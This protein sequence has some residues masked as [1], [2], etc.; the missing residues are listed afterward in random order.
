MSRRLIVIG[1]VVVVAVVTGLIVWLA[2]GRRPAGPDFREKK[3]EE[4]REYL[5]SEAFRNMDRE[6]RRGIARRAME[7]MMTGRARAYF[8]LPVEERV[9]YLD[10]IIDEMESRRREFR[11][12]RGEFRRG[13]RG[14]EER[15]E[16]RGG[17]GERVRFRSA[18]PDGRGGR[19]GQGRPRWGR[20]RRG[21]WRSPERRRRRSEFVDAETRAIRAKFREALR[22]RMRERGMDFGRR[23]G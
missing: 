10:K 21:R 14:S 7:Q 2:V 11:S 13:R 1:S 3:P 8:E 18:G 22:Q 5:R 19:D 16:T 9:V 23:R 4:I 12:M 15:R 20:G 6:A 17:Q